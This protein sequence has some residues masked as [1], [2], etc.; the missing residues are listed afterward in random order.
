MRI[1]G[2]SRLSEFVI[3]YGSECISTVKLVQGDARPKGIS[4][5]QT[6]AVKL[7]REVKLSDCSLTG[8]SESPC[9]H[10]CWTGLRSHKQT[11]TFVHNLTRVVGNKSTHMENTTIHTNLEEHIDRQTVSLPLTHIHTPLP[12]NSLHQGRGAEKTSLSHYSREAWPYI[13]MIREQQ[14]Q[15]L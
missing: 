14:D 7:R 9:T 4:R 3:K 8:I 15:A 2:L 1:S 5:F 10:N 11:H 13:L 12:P 6:K